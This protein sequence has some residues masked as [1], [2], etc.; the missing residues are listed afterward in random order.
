MPSPSQ[1]HHTH[2]W[3]P[4]YEKILQEHGERLYLTHIGRYQNRFA[5]ARGKDNEKLMEENLML[6]RL[7]RGIKRKKFVYDK[8][9]ADELMEAQDACHDEF[10]EMFDLEEG[11]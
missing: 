1:E 4:I 11:V 8:L 7:W 2:S 5:M 3:R 9:S 6:I 10:E